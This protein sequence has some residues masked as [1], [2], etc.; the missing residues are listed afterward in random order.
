MARTPGG[1][2]LRV[3][4]LEHLCANGPSLSLPA[5]ADGLTER[6]HGAPADDHPEERLE[7]YMA[8]YHDHVPPLVERG[9]LSY[10]QATDTVTLAA[11]ADVCGFFE[12]PVGAAEFEAL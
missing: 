11:D 1:Q 2:N 10:D 3:V 4:V 6:I 8:L 9:Y 12:R 5:V 7:I